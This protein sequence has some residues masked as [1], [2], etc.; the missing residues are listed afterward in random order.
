[1]DK[2]RKYLEGRREDKVWVKISLT[3]NDTETFPVTGYAGSKNRLDKL[4]AELGPAAGEMEFIVEDDLPDTLDIAIDTHS[5][6]GTYPTVALLGTEEKGEAY[7]A[8]VERLGPV[9]TT[10]EKEAPN[11]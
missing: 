6:D 7:A 11:E 5:I 10:I 1:M 9:E 8:A 4:E 2:L 3:R